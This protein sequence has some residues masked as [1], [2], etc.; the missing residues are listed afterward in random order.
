MFKL[1]TKAGIGRKPFPFNTAECPLFLGEQ[2]ET[3]YLKLR[4]HSECCMVDADDYVFFSQFSWK[5][6]N[7]GYVIR[8]PGIRDYTPENKNR[9]IHISLHRLVNKTP[10]NLQTDHINHNKLDNRKSN[11]R[12]VTVAENNYNTTKN[13]S[14]CV[15]VVWNK[16]AKAWQAQSQIKRKKIYLGIYKNKQDAIDARKKW[17]SSLDGISK[18]PPTRPSKTWPRSSPSRNY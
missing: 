11:L 16:M 15:G 5:L 9:R 7:H 8:T 3:K 14:G 17:E 6:D 10:D 12:S 2:M 18:N 13:T 1:G 4:N